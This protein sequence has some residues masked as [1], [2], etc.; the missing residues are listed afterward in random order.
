MPEFT[1]RK[2]IGTSIIAVPSLF[3]GWTAMA[4]QSSSSTPTASPEA[5]PGAS[6]AASP[7]TG[8]T[9]VT[10]NAIDINWEEKELTIPADTDVT[11]TVVNKGLLQHDFVIDDLQIKSDLLNGG[12]TADIT[13]N[14]PAGS[15]EYYCSVPGHKEAGMVGTLTVQ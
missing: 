10:L 7:A 4:S 8:G 3:V 5:S 9:A 12:D 2:L 11:I 13:I 1:R 6:P 14:A 15:Y